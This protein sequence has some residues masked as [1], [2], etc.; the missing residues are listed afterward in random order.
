VPLDWYR[1]ATFAQFPD[2]TPLTIRRTFTSPFASNARR[3]FC[4][5][6]GTQLTSWNERTKVDADFISLT[7]GSLLDDDLAVLEELGIL[8]A[9]SDDESSPQVGSQIVSLLSPQGFATRGA[10]WFESM[11]DNG[12]L[13]RIK[14]QKGGHI[15]NNGSVRVEWEIVEWTGNDDSNDADTLTGKR[16]HG[17]I[18]QDDVPMEHS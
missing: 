17:D 14:R 2:E 5:Y 3:Q 6:C 11:V 16:K 13:G 9:D 1:S 8:P 15:S 10:P 12:R 7:L 18:E 4:G